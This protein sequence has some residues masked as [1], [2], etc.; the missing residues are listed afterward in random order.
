M[1]EFTPRWKK[2]EMWSEWK[3]CGWWWSSL[4]DEKS[5]GCG[6]NGKERVSGSVHPQITKLKF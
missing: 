3:L 1:V 4:Q 2:L 5:L 6:V